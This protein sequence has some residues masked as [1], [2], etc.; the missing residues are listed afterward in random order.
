MACC[1]CRPAAG[2]RRPHLGCERP[3]VEA[4]RGTVVVH[5]SL[6]AVE[7]LGA[8]ERRRRLAIA[9]LCPVFKFLVPSSISSLGSLGLRPHLTI[10]F[11]GGHGVI[12]QCMLCLRDDT[13]SPTLS[14]LCM[15]HS[16]L[17]IALTSDVNVL[18][19]RPWGAA[20]MRLG[21]QRGV[22]GSMHAVQAVLPHPRSLPQRLVSTPPLAGAS[23]SGRCRVAA[24]ESRTAP[25]R[26]VCLRACNPAAH[27]LGGDDDTAPSSSG[28]DDAAPGVLPNAAHRL[29]AAVRNALRGLGAVA[30]VCVA[31][32]MG[33]CRPA[34]AAAPSRWGGGG[35]CREG[36]AC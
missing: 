32:L 9:V 8:Q 15:L 23:T 36:D 1:V 13:S 5:S 28:R 31:S 6:R 24:S 19:T 12:E 20:I 2:V 34:H 27:G 33:S 35:A 10:L 26:G 25:R 21:A 3:Q 29:P 4:I 14:C 16:A 18:R 7:R 30:L 17:T 22:H 11:L